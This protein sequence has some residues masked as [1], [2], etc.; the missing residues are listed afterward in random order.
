MR[1]RVGSAT[2]RDVSTFFNC[3][4]DLV[5]VLDFTPTLPQHQLSG[6]QLTKPIQTAY[7]YPNIHA[8][9]VQRCPI[10]K[11]S[12]AAR[13]TCQ[14]NNAL[15]ATETR[16]LRLLPFVHGQRKD[17]G[18]GREIPMRL[19]RC[20]TTCSAADD[21]T[22]RVYDTCSTAGDAAILCNGD[23]GACLACCAVAARTPAR[24]FL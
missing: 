18:L 19:S 20:M 12:R 17:R 23:T 14:A 8:R 1:W 7:K 3:F 22:C 21:R 11:D 5:P 24:D 10:I 16:K 2:T 9:S 6:P 13:P 15:C 4:Y